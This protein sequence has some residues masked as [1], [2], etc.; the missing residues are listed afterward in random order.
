MTA[1]AASTDKGALPMKPRKAS[2]R[3]RTE[4]ETADVASAVLR[5]VRAVGRRCAD[6]DPEDLAELV[7]IDHA[8]HDWMAKAVDGLRANDY[9][10]ADIAE[11]LGVTKQ[12]VW[13]RF[14]RST[15]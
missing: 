12:A 2:P 8:V 7:A 4:Y 1:T 11:V 6:G 15:R 3:R 5:L 14:P 9:S 13:Q 10:D